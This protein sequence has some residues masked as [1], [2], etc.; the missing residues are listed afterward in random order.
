MQI[1]LSYFILPI[2]FLFLSKEVI[3]FKMYGWQ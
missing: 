3:L 2:V 1:R